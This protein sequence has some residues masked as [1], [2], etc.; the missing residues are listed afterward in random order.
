ME[1]APSVSAQYLIS[2][3]RRFGGHRGKINLF[4]SDNF[5]TFVSDELKNFLSSN[6]INWKYILSPWW[7]EFYERLIR[8]V[9][10]TLRK[11]LGK[12]R[13]N[14]EELSTIITEVEGV[15]NT[16]PLTYLYD[17]DD[18]T[19]ITPSHLIIGRNLLQNVNNSNIGNFDMTKDECTRRYKYLKTTVEHFW[20]RFSQE[21]MNNLREHQIY[22]RRKYDSFNKLIV[23]DMVI[24]KDDHKVPRLQ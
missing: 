14:Y 11:V 18:I 13:L 20:N 19:A 8:I 10:S 3:L 24:I 2:C 21:Y 7:G 22:N 9:K 16:R 15:I 17:D 1:L 12:S 5:Q 6:D 4:I 23:N